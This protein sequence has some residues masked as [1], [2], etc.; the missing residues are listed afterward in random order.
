M[1]VRKKEGLTIAQAAAR[2]C[3]GIASVTRWVKNPNPKQ[4][5]NKPATKIDMIALARDVQAFPDAY[6]AERARRLGVSEKGIGHALRR[7]NISYKETLRHPKADEDERH[8]F[9]ETI[10]AYKAQNHV[11]VIGALIGKYLLA[12][13][14]FK[15]NIDA[16][17]F[18][19]WTVYDLLPK[20]PPASV[21]VMDN[22]IFHKRQDIQNAITQAGHAL[23][24]LPAYSPDLNPI[25]HK[26]AQ[27]KAIRKQQNQTVE[28][29]FRIESFYVT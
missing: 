13:G 6:Q 18:F 7:M 29:L 22:A 9:Q 27:A 11:N 24:Y 15:S 2:F 26:W 19:G 5:R 14:L 23:E 4:T 28:Q 25:E 3:V 1:S 17:T 10:K 20:L 8:I 21:V 12:V 16:D